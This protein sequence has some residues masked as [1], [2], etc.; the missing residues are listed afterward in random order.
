MST[1]SVKGAWKF[2]GPLASIF[3]LN[4]FGNLPGSDTSTG[5]AKVV[6]LCREVHKNVLRENLLKAS[7]QFEGVKGFFV[8]DFPVKRDILNYDDIR[9][10]ASHFKKEILISKRFTRKRSFFVR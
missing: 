10:I 3:C 6:S 5:I 1:D 2:I 4:D 8:E 7:D 9:V